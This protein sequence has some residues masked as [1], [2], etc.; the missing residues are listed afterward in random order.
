[1]TFTTV[2]VDGGFAHSAGAFTPPATA[3]YRATATLVFAH[4]AAGDWR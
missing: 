4:S 2:T 1:M 3:L